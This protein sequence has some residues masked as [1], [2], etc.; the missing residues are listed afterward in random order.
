[1]PDEDFT[2]LFPEW[3]LSWALRIACRDEIKF[4]GLPVVH[5][6][7]SS[8]PTSLD[9]LF[10][11]ESDKPEMI[12]EASFRKGYASRYGISEDQFKTIYWSL[13]PDFLIERK[14]PSLCVL[15]E[16]K[17]GE[18]IPKKTWTHPKEKRYYDFLKDATSIDQ[19]GFCYIIP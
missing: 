3:E 15:V 12:P 18:S 7:E 4:W 1:M 9:D 6:L 11:S 14:D 16:A 13:R 5:I 8:G 2:E 19:K 17:G 10:P